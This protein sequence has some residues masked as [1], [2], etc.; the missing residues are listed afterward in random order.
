MEPTPTCP[1]DKGAT[2][3]PT[4]RPRLSELPDPYAI[5]D[6]RDHRALYDATRKLWPETTLLAWHRDPTAAFGGRSAACLT[7]FGSDGVALG[8]LPLDCPADPG[9]ASSRDF[10]RALAAV[11]YLDAATSAKVSE[12]RAD[13]RRAAARKARAAVEEALS[14]AASAAEDF[15]VA[16]GSHGID[17]E[18]ARRMAED[19]DAPHVAELDRI[20]TRLGPIVAERGLRWQTQAAKTAS[21]ARTYG[22]SVEIGRA[23]HGRASAS[24]SLPVASTALTGLRVRVSPDTPENREAVLRNVSENLRRRIIFE[25]RASAKTASFSQAP[26]LGGAAAVELRAD[27]AAFQAFVDQFSRLTRSETVETSEVDR[28][29]L[30]LGARVI[31]LRGCRYTVEYTPEGQR[32]ALAFGVDA[33]GAAALSEVLNPK[34]P[35]VSGQSDD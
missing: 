29:T 19:L 3:T 23:I 22:A 25:D 1:P 14:A 31:P 6:A 17:A 8:G 28:V 30:R 7:A 35:A 33:E 12:V 18:R 11:R 27:P 2:V 34:A 9:E 5:L 16:C 4:G 26:S 10:E 13:K 24:E 32:M 15:A 20:A 21:V